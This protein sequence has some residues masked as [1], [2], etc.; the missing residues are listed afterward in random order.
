MFASALSVLSVIATLAVAAP[1]SSPSCTPDFKGA[2]VRIYNAAADVAWTVPSYAQA[3]TQVATGPNATSSEW[4]F[5]A[6][7]TGKKYTI[8]SHDEANHNLL[9]GI[10]QYGY[11]TLRSIKASKNP[12]FSVACSSCTKSSNKEWSTGYTIAS[13]CSI[14]NATTSY[15]VQLTDGKLK[16]SAPD[17]KADE[18]F[19]FIA[20]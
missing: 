8:L 18:V 2:S 3:R 1:A 19:T 14:V 16:F 7:T 17:G 5:V 6:D 12:A 10:G 9:V 15:Q 13:G 11:L 4:D 20:A